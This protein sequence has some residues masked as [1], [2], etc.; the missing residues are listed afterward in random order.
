VLE[1][2]PLALGHRA[3]QVGI[4]AH[5]VP[6]AMPVRAPA[7]VARAPA[8]V[9]LPRELV[10][11]G[12]FEDA[13]WASQRSSQVVV[14]LARTSLGVTCVIGFADRLGVC[15]APDRD[16][17]FVDLTRNGSRRFCSTA[18]QNRVKAARYR[19]VSAPADRDPDLMAS[20]S[21][22]G[23]RVTPG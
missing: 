16:R 9:E 22:R 13:C 4:G 5:S 21:V 17:V 3:A 18:C 8:P 10:E 2:P 14:A 6:P 15:A 19:R 20:P 11:P 1:L 7:F 12:R 23:G